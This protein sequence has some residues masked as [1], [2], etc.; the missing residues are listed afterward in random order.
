MHW[1]P[2]H[3]VLDNISCGSYC[4]NLL[5]AL[6]KSA[7]RIRPIGHTTSFELVSTPNHPKKHINGYFVVFWGNL[8]NLGFNLR[9]GSTYKCSLAASHVAKRTVFL[10][11]EPQFTTIVTNV[12]KL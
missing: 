4:S 2:K 6:P 7:G 3:L 9:Q 1:V 5:L 8:R 10:P 11:Q 12:K